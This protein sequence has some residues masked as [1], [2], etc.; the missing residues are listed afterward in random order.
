MCVSCFVC[1]LVRVD[2][3]YLG[4]SFFCVGRGVG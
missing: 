1:Y 4:G 3:L 2:V